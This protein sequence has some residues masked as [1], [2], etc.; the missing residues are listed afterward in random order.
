[1][2]I[3]LTRASLAPLILTYSLTTRPPM[4]WHYTNTTKVAVRV[5]STHLHTAAC[6]VAAT[7]LTLALT[8][9]KMEITVTMAARRSA[10][11]L[12]EQ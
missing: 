11:K 3:P 6:I 9:S 10:S 7:R 8:L 4:R 12:L 1:M 5:A 2:P